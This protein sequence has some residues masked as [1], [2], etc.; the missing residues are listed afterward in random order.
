MIFKKPS[1]EFRGFMILRTQILVKVTS[2]EDKEM[3][4][5]I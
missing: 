1:T 3:S 4:N 5:I 2:L